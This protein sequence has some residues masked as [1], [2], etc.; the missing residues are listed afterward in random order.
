MSGLLLTSRAGTTTLTAKPDPLLQRVMPAPP[1]GLRAF[2]QDDEV[3]V[4]AEV[5]DRTAS[6]PHRVDI[7]TTVKSA[8]GTAVW[9]HSDERSSTELQGD[10]GGYGHTVRVPMSGLTPG[11]YVLNVEARSR[12]G[13]TAAREVPFQVLALAPPK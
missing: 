7:I 13:Q 6:T 3:L 12:L 4:F 1:V 10:S 8:S 11:S 5:Y 2:P 9:S